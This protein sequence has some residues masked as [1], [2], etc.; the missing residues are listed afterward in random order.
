[1]LFG[2]SG[3]RFWNSFFVPVATWQSQGSVRSLVNL[4]K[5]ATAVDA[6]DDRAVV[7]FQDGAFQLVDLADPAQPVVLAEHKRLH[8]FKEWTGV[9]ILGNRIA[10]FGDD[11]VEIIQ[12]TGDGSETV[13]SI[14]RGAIGG[15]AAAEPLGDKIVMAGNRGL[16]VT[17]A[18]GSAPSQLLRRPLRG[19]A[20]VRD[21]LILSDGESVLISNSSLLSQGRVLSQIRLGR[22]FGPHRVRAFGDT[23]VVIGDTGALVLDVR[24]PEQPRTLSKLHT[25]QAGSIYDASQVGGRIFLLGDRGLLVL[26]EKGQAIRE[27]IDVKPRDRVTAMGRH[28]V[29]VG[30][31]QLQVVDATPL[32]LTTVAAAPG[33]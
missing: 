27:G 32:R 16:I 29:S 14:D 11:G 1:V 13:A 12:L 15:I 10:I 30:E 25:R 9:R 5:R 33:Q 17:Q 20:V 6:T 28:L 4:G 26:D 24:N 18:D 19:L 31:E 7:L 22:A 21:T 2:P 8:D 23:A 3:R